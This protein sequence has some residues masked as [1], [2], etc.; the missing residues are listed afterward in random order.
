MPLT[1]RRRRIRRLA[2]ASI[3][4]LCLVALL[5]PGPDRFP[6]RAAT[7]NHLVISEIQIGGAAAGDEFVE[8][9][10]PTHSA[11]SL[12]SWKLTRKNSSGT[13]GNL[14]SSAGFS[15]SIPTR[16]FFLITPQTG[17]TGSVSADLKY[18]QTSN[19][20]AASYTVLLYDNTG[21]LVG[22]AGFGAVVDFE[23]APFASSPA[24]NDSI[25][26]KPGAADSTGGNG[27]DTDNNASDFALRATSEPQNSSSAPEPPSSATETATATATST[28]PEVNTST[29]TATPT[30]T[31]T[32]TA[33]LTATPSGTPTSTPTPTN[34]HTLTPSSTLA[35]EFIVINEVV[36]DPQQDWSDSS[37][38][39]GVGF[40]AFP[41]AG[42]IGDTD[43]WIELRNTGS[44]AV[45]LQTGSGWTL[46]IA[47]SGTDVLNFRTPGSAVFVFSNG[48]SLTNFKP[49]EYLVIGNPPGAMNNDVYLSLHSPSG[50]LL[51]DVEIGNDPESDGNGDG[52]P[53]GGTSNGN[54]GGI[55]DEAVARVPDSVDTADDVADFARQQATIGDINNLP[56]TVTPTSTA[57]GT[58]TLTPTETLTATPSQTPTE[59]LTPAP[60][61]II[62]NEVVTDPQQDWS[63]SSGGNGVG[64]DAFPG[65]GTIGDTDEWVELRNTGTGPV[66]LQAGNGWTLT[67]TDSGTDLLNFLTP[68]SAVLVFSNGGSLTDFKPGEYLVIGN[69]PG[70][71]NND[72]YLSL[73]APSGSLVGDVEI[74]ND[75]EGDGSGDGAP[76]GGTSNG[77]ANGITDEAV[78][79]WPNSVDTGDDVADFARQ[80]ATIGET[81]N[82]PSTRTPTA[83]ATA[84][85]T[86]T[87][88][89]ARAVVINEIMWMGAVASSSDEWIELHNTTGLTIPLNGW[90]LTID[91]GFL[92]EDTVLNLGG[93][94][95][96]YGYFLMERTD[97]DTVSDI[98]ADFIYS[99]SLSNDGRVLNLRDPSFTSID[100]AN[101]NGG[102][103][104]AGDD[105]LR[106]SMERINASLIDSDGNW[107]SNYG[108]VVNGHD[109]DGN[110]LRATPRQPN[111][112]LI[113]TPTPTAF[114]RYTSVRINE[115][116]P[117]AG[118]VEDWASYGLTHTADEFIE[119][120]NTSDQP[121][122]IGYWMIDDQEEGST[123]FVIWPG[124]IIEP[125]QYFAVYG[126]TSGVTFNDDMDSARLLYPDGTVVDEI[127]WDSSIGDDESISR[128]SPGVG[129]WEYG[130]QPSPGMIN[131]PH[132]VGSKYGPRPVPV[133][134]PV[135]NAR[136]FDDGA[137][138]T[139]EG[140][141]IGP[142]PLFGGRVIYME[143]ESGVGIAVYLGRGSW[144]PMEAGRIIR[145]EGYL[146]TRS[147]ERQ[148]YVRNPWLFSL[149][150]PGPA[151]APVAEKTG[152]INDTTEGTLV[153]LVGEVV[154]LESNAFWIDDG[155][156]AARVFFRSSTGVLR[157]KVRRGQIWSATG[158]VSEFTTRTSRAAGHRLL[159]RYVADV[160]RV[161]G[162]GIAND[163][164]PTAT[165]P[166]DGTPFSTA[167]PE[168][169]DTA[170]P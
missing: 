67:I 53:D 75:P 117:N 56:A 11:V 12:A 7:A 130:W 55:T 124:T 119:L 144:P 96:P 3:A 73:R 164:V 79:R 59:T 86:A 159:V 1:A 142:F 123:P 32:L 24:N 31:L 20:V 161:T 166:P 8:L 151:P 88:F 42:A 33:S 87:A 83:T 29:A 34:T 52:A 84:S 82:L 126:D 30:E 60:E 72:V 139:L 10:N 9:Y 106:A 168:P 14:V 6:V 94:I 113:S 41:G 44:A 77:N 54:A 85:P 89:P 48:G 146:R 158:I 18:S 58:E 43:E 51:D 92:P 50:A 47:D 131:R 160:F 134:V 147:G 81:N 153:T 2:Y 121:V 70:A 114:A 120:F 95:E 22:K 39:N 148:L 170:V 132:P 135:R 66:N 63:D 4:A 57:T 104:P 93:V 17:Y 69:P 140:K 128:S 99:G 165:S 21:A 26:R 45:N 25:E 46:T 137:W 156:G 61:F 150:P 109:A 49:G 62:I 157:P 110:P 125:G 149:G 141:A 15:G 38:G 71:M 36:T 68:G 108:H 111:S 37:G 115:V 27:E 154:R 101:G 13:E 118:S 122:D 138:I 143:D 76:D 105:T 155:S 102:P 107:S 152:N 167:L 136:S 65:A 145:A 19:T 98:A 100:T 28:Q 103:W 23:G 35:P 127:G 40:D 16:G 97:D 163:T 162:E 116:A 91:D 74:G 133:Q 169:T 112:A 90:T 5:L 80:Q 64:F 78:A 129:S